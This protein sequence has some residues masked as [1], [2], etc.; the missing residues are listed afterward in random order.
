MKVAE[1]IHCRAFLGLV[2]KDAVIQLY[3]VSKGEAVLVGFT[4]GEENNTTTVIN[5]CDDM[6]ISQCTSLLILASRL[7]LVLMYLNSMTYTT[8][9]LASRDPRFTSPS[10][11]S[12]QEMSETVINPRSED[13]I[14]I[15]PAL[16]SG[17][18]F[19]KL[20]SASNIYSG[21][22][23]LKVITPESPSIID[24]STK[25]AVIVMVPS[26][27][28]ATACENLLVALI[29]LL[30]PFRAN[31]PSIPI[32]VLSEQAHELSRATTEVE[33]QLA[34]LFNNIHFVLGTG[35][36]P[37][38]LTSVHVD[39]CDI[40][41]V[42]SPIS[43]RVE[44]PV[45]EFERILTDER[46]ILASLNL[47]F[48]QQ[49]V[50]FVVELMYHHNS[51]FLCF[52]KTPRPIGYPMHWTMQNDTPLGEPYESLCP[53]QSE[54]YVLSHSMLDSL[55]IQ[56]IFSPALVTFWENVIAQNLLMKMPAPRHMLGQPAARVFEYVLISGTGIIIG[57]LNKSKESIWRIPF[58]SED[59]LE[60]LDELLV[61]RALTPRPTFVSNE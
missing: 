41:V 56:C 16:S 40:V 51:T 44:L 38:H 42:I 48:M 3:R 19:H 21:I 5:P 47:R 23:S 25:H 22:E 10:F 27:Q 29:C 32:F 61:L 4:S 13:T 1:H 57:V 2:L 14:S 53:N 36:N 33:H 17:R 20:H 18:S 50:R 59:L 60:P 45:Q 24:D 34:E 54:G 37:D 31:Y 15:P 30:K 8:T 35:D 49:N 58:G 7:S 46:V 9:A 55:L 28:S 43:K 26:K 11:E 52:S 6:Y 12:K 39:T